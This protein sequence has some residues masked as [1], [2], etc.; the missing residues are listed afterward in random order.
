MPFDTQG[1]LK[2]VEVALRAMEQIDLPP[3][4]KAKI[5]QHTARRLFRLPGGP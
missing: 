5:Y 2:Y 4:D 1:G 3:E